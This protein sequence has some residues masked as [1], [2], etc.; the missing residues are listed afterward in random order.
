MEA[1]LKTINDLDNQWVFITGGEPLILQDI[2]TL[3]DRLKELGKKVGLTTNGTIPNYSITDHVDRLGI[4]IDGA[5]EIHDRNRGAGT[6]QSAIN[7]ARAVIGK[8]ETVLMATVITEDY[9]D[10][11]SIYKNVGFDHLQI[12]K[13]M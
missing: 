2:L 13:V 3:C 11:R 10:L 5:E 6:W 7:F 12:T 1:S 8:T 9:S 4:S